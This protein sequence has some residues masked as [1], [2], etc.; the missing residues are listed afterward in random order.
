[1]SSIFS[2]RNILVILALAAILLWIGVFQV[3]AHCCVLSVHFFDVGQGDSIFIQAPGGTQILIDGGR[4]RVVL[5]KL[6]R[7]MPFFDRSIDVVMLTHPEL[8]HME[9]LIEV[10]KRYKVG[11]V[12]WTGVE[13]TIPEYESF[14]KEA[15][16]KKAR[17]LIAAPGAQIKIGEHQ[18][19]LDILYPFENFEGM[20]IEKKLNFSSIVSRLTY[21]ETKFLFTGDIE[22][23]SEQELVEGG[24]DISADVLKAAHHGSKTSSIKEF[25]ERVDPKLAVIQVGRNNR[26][27]HP[28]A[29]T[30]ETF[31]S[32]N[33]PVLRNDINGNIVILSDGKNLKIKQ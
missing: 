9:G 17:V 12:I 29:Q 5:E 32:L 4:G 22:K 20:V 18:G 30:L 26:Y 14:L 28:H 6:S 21:G 7:A 10:L 31:K 1:M 19:V 2:V 3:A 27:G 13:R 23:E 24:G 11:T 33:I 8:D 25:V 16:S 15:Y